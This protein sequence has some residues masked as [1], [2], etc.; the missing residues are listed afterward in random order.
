MRHY[1]GSLPHSTFLLAPSERFTTNTEPVSRRRGRPAMRPGVVG[2][3]EV[4]AYP[5]SSVKAYAVG[6]DEAVPEVTAMTG[7]SIWQHSRVAYIAIADLPEPLRAQV[8]TAQDGLLELH[9]IALATGVAFTMERQDGS[10]SA[11]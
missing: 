11:L 6:L 2:L 5:D 1:P 8:Q 7:Y 9:R 4:H 10:L 3:L